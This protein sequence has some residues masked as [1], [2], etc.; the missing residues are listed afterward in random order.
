MQE[1]YIRARENPYFEGLLRADDQVPLN[2]KEGTNDNNVFQSELDSNETRFEKLVLDDMS[3]EVIDHL[4]VLISEDSDFNKQHTSSEPNRT[5]ETNEK[6][7]AL[8]SHA[9]P[10]NIEKTY[11]VTRRKEKL[12]NMMLPISAALYY[13]NGVS[14]EI[15]IVESCESINKLNAYLK[16]R[17]DDV[18]AGVPGKFLHAVI[19][20][21]DAGNFLSFN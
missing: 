20:S 17:K 1:P 8:Q 16:A 2:S 13:T 21:D 14:S 11:T 5:T 9:I 6:N 4:P 3:E 10:A 7:Q 19:G 15:E 12:S 18:N